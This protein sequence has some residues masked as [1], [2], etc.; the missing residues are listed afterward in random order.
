LWQ[1]V[2][3]FELH[4]GLCF[5]DKTMNEDLPEIAAYNKAVQEAL[6]WL[7]SQKETFAIKE[8]DS[9]VLVEEGKFYGMGVLK[10]D[11]ISDIDSL[12]ERLTP[13]P[14][15]EVIK[16]MIRQYV[17]RYPAKVLRFE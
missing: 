4:P 16:S 2:R 17:D 13:Y 5:L 7:H 15:N 11:G 14:E 10:D 12:K 8:K 9:C 6:R 3:K 1:I